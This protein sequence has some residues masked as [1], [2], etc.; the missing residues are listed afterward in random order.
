MGRR[1]AAAE[2]N[3][4]DP[5]AALAHELAR[6]RELLAAGERVDDASAH[7]FRRAMKRARA[8][9]RLM[10]DAVGDHAYE[11]ENRALRDAARVLGPMRDARVLR[12]ALAGLGKRAKV[13]KARPAAAAPLRETVSEAAA[14]TADWR[15]PRPKWPLLAGG[16]E[17]LY[18]HGRDAA[19]AAEAQPT[20][21][22][23]HE[24]RKQVKRLGAA[25]AFLAPAGVKRVK[26]LAKR[27]DA[28][29]DDLGDDHDLAVLARRTPRLAPGVRAKVRKRRRKLQ[30][31]ALKAAGRLFRARPRKFLK[32]IARARVKKD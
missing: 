3:L 32:R 18:R 2:E 14:R 4:P 6:A 22:N 29:A 25:L 9:L 12:E 30:K 13:P 28:V 17:R 5:R 23:L 8:L 19:R 15:L 11:R 1:L 7:E 31:R 26:K 27:A 10:R 16:L 24:S 20:D 21:R